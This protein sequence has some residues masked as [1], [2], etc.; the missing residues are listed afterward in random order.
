MAE[1]ITRKWFPDRNIL[2][3]QVTAGSKVWIADTKL[4]DCQPAEWSV[5]ARRYWTGQTTGEPE[6]EVL[7][8]G[9]VYFPDWRAKPFGMGAGWL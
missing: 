2:R 3:V 9:T 6:F 4:H 5:N 7:V 1:E 8:D